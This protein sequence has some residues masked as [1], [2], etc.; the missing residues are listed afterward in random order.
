MFEFFYRINS[1]SATEGN[2]IGLY[3]ALI[4]F[5]VF[6][7]SACCFYLKGTKNH[8]KVGNMLLIP[9]ACFG[10]SVLLCWLFLWTFAT[11]GV[12]ITSYVPFLKNF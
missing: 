11:K 5:C 6:A 10:A 2:N 3:V 1:Q 8:N 9:T 7:I 12:R 4:F